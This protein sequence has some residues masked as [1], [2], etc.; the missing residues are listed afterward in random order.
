[1]RIT[2]E[3]R[4]Q[5]LLQEMAAVSILRLTPE[6]FIIYRDSVS[7][8]SEHLLDVTDDWKE[9]QA[10]AQHDEEAKTLLQ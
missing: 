2:Q 5:V 6:N 8:V 7:F 1:M 3:A 9:Y 4:T 10:Q